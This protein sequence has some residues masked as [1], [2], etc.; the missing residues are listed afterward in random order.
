MPRSW[1]L[2]RVVLALCIS[3]QLMG[4]AYTP[5][6]TTAVNDSDT[7]RILSGAVLFSDVS[8]SALENDPQLLSQ[9]VLA[10][11]P[12]MHLFVDLYVDKDASSATKLRQLLKAIFHGGML[13][14]DYDPLKTYTAAE[15]FYFQQ[16]NCLSFTNMFVALGREAGLKVWF[17]E[18]KVPPTWDMQNA[19]THIYYRHMNAV[20]KT[21]RGRHIIDL[22][23]ENYDLDY[24][25]QRV[26]DDYAM[27][28]FF[29]NRAMELLFDKD[30]QG[31]F[32]H[33]RAALK[34]EPKQA[35]LWG[36]LGSLYRR[37]E[38]YPEAELAFLKSLQ[39]DPR[40]LLAMSNLG[41]LY[42][43][44]GRESEAEAL[45]VRVVNHRRKNPYYRYYLAQE[46]LDKRQLEIALDH[47][48]AAIDA[49][50]KDHRFHFLAAKVSSA[51]GNIHRAQK[52]LQRATAL[53]KNP[54]QKERYNHKLD[55]LASR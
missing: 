46:A 1:R 24:P 3:L 42:R 34:L 15:T 14:L 20:V 37:A 50:G 38:H 28:Q 33:L 18:V 11:N 6:V 52:Y 23:M 5:S 39:M 2:Y 29:N 36:N 8:E 40:N 4:C 48:E 51:Q 21:A 19:N 25:Q 45:D 53:T 41:R 44:L 7:A 55:A 49:Y 9:P 35:F 22:N 12:D 32:R 43:Q 13:G 27:A 16:G 54:E 31:S 17:N 10:L 30:W 47:I 26:S